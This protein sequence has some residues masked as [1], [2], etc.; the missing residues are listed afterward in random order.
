MCY[1]GAMFHTREQKKKICT[2][3]PFAKT[4]DLVG[5]SV[6]LI[7]LRELFSGPHRFGELESALHG[8][9]TR[10]LSEKLRML[11]EKD[12]IRRKEI[13]GKPPR[14]DYSLTKKGKGLHDIYSAM[15]VYGEKYL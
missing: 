7:I 13:V 5:D 9:S 3:C 2:E 10:T 15:R 11:E 12:I 8:V 14:V 1:Y 6:I 4:A